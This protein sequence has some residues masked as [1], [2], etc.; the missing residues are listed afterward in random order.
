MIRSNV[1]VFAVAVLSRVSQKKQKSELCFATKPTG[2][3]RLDEPPEKWGIPEK[4]LQ[5]TVQTRWS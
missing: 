1:R 3:H 5:N 2:F 4:I